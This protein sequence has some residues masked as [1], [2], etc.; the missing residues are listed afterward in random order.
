[1]HAER[2]GL[3][4]R[5][6]LE[7]S[8]QLLEQ[9]AYTRTTYDIKSLLEPSRRDGSW[10]VRVRWFGFTADDDSYVPVETLV[11]DQPELM[12]AYCERNAVPA[13]CRDAIHALLP[14]SRSRGR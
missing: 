9:V 7:P 6:G 8:K 11:E 4:E 5:G 12:R 2:L 3:F 14:R 13:A 10:V 1:M